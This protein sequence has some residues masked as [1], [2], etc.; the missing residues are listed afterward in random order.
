M[1]LPGLD[2][3]VLLHL[4]DLKL[5]QKLDKLAF[6][7]LQIIIVNSSVSSGNPTGGGCHS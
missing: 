6:N 7:L 3:I 2:P 1:D 5:E 4:S